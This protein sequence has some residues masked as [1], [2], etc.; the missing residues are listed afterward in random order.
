MSIADQECIDLTLPKAKARNM[1]VIAKRPIANAAWRHEEAPKEGYHVDYWKRL[2]KLDYDFTK[3][4][5]RTSSAPDG[6]AGTALR[7]TLAVPGVHVAIVGTTKP[8]R[9]KQNAELLRAGGALAKERF[10]AIRAR[11]KEVAEADWTGRT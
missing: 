11:W 7:F 1:G 8:E 9:W 4:D 5:A 6:A 10:E 3:G 2:K